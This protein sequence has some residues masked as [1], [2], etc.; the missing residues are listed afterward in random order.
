MDNEKNLNFDPPAQKETEF[1][2]ESS[3][4]ARNRTVML[5]PEITGQVRARIAQELEQGYTTPGA[6]PSAAFEAAGSPLPASTYAPAGQRSA[7]DT[8]D[9]KP[10]A[11]AAAAPVQSSKPGITW[12]KETK[13]VGFLISFDSNP[14]GDVYELRS[15][16]VMI[17]SQAAPGSNCLVVKDDSVSPMHAIMRVSSSGEIQVLDQLSEFGTKIQRFGSTEEEQLSG[18]KGAVEHGDIIKFG[19]RKFHVCI[20]A[21]G[22]EA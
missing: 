17:T 12:Q 4:R 19:N 11:P 7:S 18:D 14:N 13:I 20:I 16:R 2:N 8:G 6:K 3:S 15:G 9:F 5:T 22:E 1:S 21:V 10:V